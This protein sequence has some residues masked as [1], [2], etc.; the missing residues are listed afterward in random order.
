MRSYVLAEDN[1][2]NNL[3][4]IY[5]MLSMQ[6]TKDFLAVSHTVYR[7]LEIF[8]DA[9]FSQELFSRLS[10]SRDTGRW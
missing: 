1:N 5:Q 7:H 9:L 3:F 8:L 4:V 6:H 2:N 10:K